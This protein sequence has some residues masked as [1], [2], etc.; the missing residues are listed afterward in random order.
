MRGGA[1]FWAKVGLRLG[2]EIARPDTL[3]VTR[4]EWNCGLL[5]WDVVRGRPDL[6]IRRI[7]RYQGGIIKGEHTGR[8]RCVRV[9]C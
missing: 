3:P 8:M 9:G 1:D 5:H 7:G 6:L 4:S 2:I